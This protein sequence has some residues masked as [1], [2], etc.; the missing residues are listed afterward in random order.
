MMGAGSGVL[1]LG[2]SAGTVGD[3]WG[4]WNSRD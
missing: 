1:G 4:G 2:Y 3:P